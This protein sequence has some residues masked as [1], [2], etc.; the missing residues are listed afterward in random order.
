MYRLQSILWEKFSIG[1]V[2]ITAMNVDM[3]RSNE[4]FSLTPTTPPPPYPPKKRFSATYQDV[5]AKK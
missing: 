1:N 3:I 5:L 2:H 4:H